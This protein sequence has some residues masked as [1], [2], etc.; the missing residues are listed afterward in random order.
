MLTRRQFILGLGASALLGN[1]AYAR[2]FEPRWLKVTHRRVPLAHSDGAAPIRVLHVSDLHLG[3]VIPLEFI[4][5]SLRRGLAEKPDLIAITGDFATGRLA[6]FS[7]YAHVLS[8]LPAAAPTFACLGNHDGGSWARRFTSAEGADRTLALLQ[9]AN[10]PCL[11]NE[12]RELRV[13]GRSVQLIGVGDLWNEMCLPVDAFRATP[14]RGS[15]MRLVLNHNP[16]AKTQLQPFDWD[17]MLSGHTHGGQ[18]RIPF[19]GAPFAPVKDK[20]YIDGLY[21][22]ERRWLH[23]SCGVGNLF[24]VRFNCR[25]EISVLT[26]G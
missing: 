2:W 1:A 20:R 15:A 10:I 3:A 25:P 26:I 22:W 24:G 13:R 18:I 8:E 12:G 23:V 4:Q 17:V 21:R 11:L 6:D 19:T 16:D 5:A 14:A 7:D 9:L